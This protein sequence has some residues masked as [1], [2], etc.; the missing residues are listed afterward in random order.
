[1]Q[2]SSE[3]EL[4]GDHGLATARSSGGEKILAAAR[5]IEIAG[6]SGDL[7]AQRGSVVG[8]MC[9]VEGRVA[10]VHCHGRRGVLSELLV[11]HAALR[12]DLVAAAVEDAA[13]Q[14]RPLGQV[15]VA[16][17]QIAATELR[18]LVLQHS[19][20]QLELVLMRSAPAVTAFVPTTTPYAYAERFELAELVDRV[21]TVQP[22][23][24]GPVA[25]LV[26]ARL[27]LVDGAVAVGAARP[28]L[29]GGE[30]AYHA[31]PAP[32][33]AVGEVDAAWAYAALIAS[34]T[35]RVVR[36]EPAEPV[37][38]TGSLT[39]FPVGTSVGIEA[40]ELLGS[41]AGRL[42]YER[43]IAGLTVFLLARPGTEPGR[44]VAEARAATA[45][46]LGWRR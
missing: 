36:A 6:V 41:V 39:R 40:D 10:W 43:E 16:A 15:L 25:L 42:V 45:P 9:F 2:Y 23:H 12:P 27:S 28:P 33:A 7:V 46:A 11:E 13:R 32:G 17:G 21:P 44:F 26:A 14:R 3:P 8:R 1:M 35:E 20:A 22:G 31:C 5:G 24:P 34:G 29:A 38:A 19:R 30:G 4:M 18:A 37:L